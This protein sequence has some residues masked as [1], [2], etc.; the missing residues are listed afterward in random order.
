MPENSLKKENITPKLNAS[1]TTKLASKHEPSPSIAVKK[2]PTI[3]KLINKNLASST[4]NRP[5]PSPQ[6]LVKNKNVSTTTIRK[7]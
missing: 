4:L 3:P 7:Q 1:A 6:I 2:P 5:S